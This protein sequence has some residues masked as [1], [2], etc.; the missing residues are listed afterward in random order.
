MKVKNTPD[1]HFF[2]V[3]F[4]TPHRRIINLQYAHFHAVWGNIAVL[5]ETRLHL[6][7]LNKTEQN[8]EVVNEVGPYIDSS[9]ITW[10]HQD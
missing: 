8:V 9:N 6:T 1:L 3:N 10:V 4:I 2:T 5:A 7:C